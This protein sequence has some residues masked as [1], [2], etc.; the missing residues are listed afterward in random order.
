[1][2][3]KI[4]LILLSM[5]FIN[6]AYAQKDSIIWPKDKLAFYIEHDVLGGINLLYNSLKTKSAITDYENFY[7]GGIGFSLPKKPNKLFS[8]DFYLN[9]YYYSVERKSS[10]LNYFSS[11]YFKSTS[12]SEINKN[13][14][15]E[16]RLFFNKKAASKGFYVNYGFGLGN[17]NY[18]LDD[19]VFEKKSNWNFVLGAG[20]KLTIK[21][22]FVNF[23][24]GMIS[25]FNYK[26]VQD[27]HYP[28]YIDAKLTYQNESSKNSN[29]KSVEYDGLSKITRTYKDFGLLNSSFIPR[30]GIN[31]GFR[32]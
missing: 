25:L 7:S 31:I 12:R 19:A 18:K 26:Y 28:I 4:V 24:L 29:L 3:I 17:Y 21:H 27:Y 23:N 14:S 30:I 32:F 2:K 13:F 8:S 6:Y 16:H 11:Y 22:F 1:M 9:Y 20:Y 15:L 10:S 5:L